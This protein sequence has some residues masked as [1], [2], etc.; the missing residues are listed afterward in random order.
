MACSHRLSC[1]E[2]IPRSVLGGALIGH[3]CALMGWTLM[4]PPGPSWAGPLGPCGSL[5]PYGPGPCG[6]LWALVGRALVGP[7]G[8]P[9]ALMGQALVAPWALMGWAIMGPMGQ[10]AAKKRG[11]PSYL[12]PFNHTD[13]K[14]P[15]ASICM[16]LHAN[17]CIHMRKCMKSIDFPMVVLIPAPPKMGP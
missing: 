14:M 16:H 13:E 9:W 11:T 12:C 6:P 15:S 5:G 8:P 3:P 10:H 1:P 17:A 2:G 7:L 4:G